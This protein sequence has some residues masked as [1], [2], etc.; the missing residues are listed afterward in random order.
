MPLSNRGASR[1]EPSRETKLPSTFLIMPSKRWKCE[2]HS[3]KPG[4]LIQ[5]MGTRGSG[6]SC[7]EGTG[8]GKGSTQGS[9]A[10]HR[11]AGMGGK[12]GSSGG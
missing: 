9:R 11:L 12:E 1:V 8:V 5:R 2:D 6:L 3:V 7:G 4:E 10:T